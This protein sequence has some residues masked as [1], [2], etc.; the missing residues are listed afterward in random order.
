MLTLWSWIIFQNR[1]ASGNVGTPSKTTSVA[2]TA[3]G[4]YAMYVWPVT[5][6]MSAVHQKRSVGLMSNVH[7]IVSIAHSK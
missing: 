2:P 6:P 1:P 3:S 5:H 4:P 7:F